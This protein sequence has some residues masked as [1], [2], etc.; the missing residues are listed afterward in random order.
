MINK[1]DGFSLRFTGLHFNEFVIKCK[2]KS[3]NII[4]K[5]LSKNIQIGPLLGQHFMNLND[6]ILIGVTEL[7][8]TQDIEK[9]VSVLKEVA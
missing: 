6:C 5:L 2:N 7:H 3:E 4:K 1:I 8:T 9:L